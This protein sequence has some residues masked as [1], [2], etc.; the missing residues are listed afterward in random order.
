M[1]QEWLSYRLVQERRA[2]LERIAAQRPTR[3]L[4][5]PRPRRTA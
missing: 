5:R 3:S 2:D 4:R 1:S